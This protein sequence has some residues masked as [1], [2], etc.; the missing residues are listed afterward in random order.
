MGFI[1]RAN[2]G[3]VQ[4][5]WKLSKMSRHLSNNVQEWFRVA[6]SLDRSCA[7]FVDLPL[8]YQ[9]A[10][11][12]LP[13]PPLRHWPCFLSVTPSNPAR[14]SPLD[15]AAPLELL[16]IRPVCHLGQPRIL[17]RGPDTT[18]VT[19]PLIGNA[20]VPPSPHCDARPPPRSTTGSSPIVVSFS[21]SGCRSRPSR[22]TRV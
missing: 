7:C 8:P 1:V 21:A 22:L 17:I 12:L 15:P 19:N 20:A 11:H 3:V 2:N 9:S 5:Q 10:L 18:T 16:Y 6:L 4:E 13:P 14:C